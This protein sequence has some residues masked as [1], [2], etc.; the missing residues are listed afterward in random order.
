M[1]QVL[2]DL[3]RAYVNFFQRRARFPRFKSRKRDQARFRIPQRVK[4]AA[5]RI[6]IPKVGRLAFASR[7]RWKATPRAPHSSGMPPAIGMST[8]V[9][10]SRCPIRLCR[11]RSRRCDRRGS[12]AE[13]FAVLSDA[14][15]GFLC[16]S[17]SVRG[18]GNCARR[19]VC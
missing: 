9:A 19:N 12:R 3:K 8:L 7:N 17:S 18:S 14:S 6:Y 15:T 11:C 1:Q 16:R 4:I 10:N 5:G 13:D 2:A